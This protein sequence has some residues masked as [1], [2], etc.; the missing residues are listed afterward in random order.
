MK[1]SAL[2]AFVVAASAAS[3]A[4]YGAAPAAPTA[5]ASA[6][7]KHNVAYCKKGHTKVIVK[8]RAEQG[9]NVHFVL[10]AAKGGQSVADFTATKAEATKSYATY[11]E[12][13]T[14]CYHDAAQK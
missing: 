4:A 14:V 12:G 7:A 5:A 8:E 1:L 3:A 10:V 2:F 11:K 6:P 9:D 13:A